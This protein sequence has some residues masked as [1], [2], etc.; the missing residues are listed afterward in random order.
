MK[1]LFLSVPCIFF[2]SLSCLY[3]QINRI[4]YENGFT[5]VHS[6]K[7]GCGIVSVVLFLKGGSFNETDEQAG[8]TNLTA[9]LLLKGTTDRDAAK[10]AFETE[11]LGASMG[12]GSS[13]DYTE[14]SMIVPA[15]N[16]APAFPIFCD[17]VNNPA[18]PEKELEKEREKVMAA[19]RSKS[20]RIFDTAY[21]C[22]NE[23]IYAGHPYHK[24]S[25][26]YEATVSS[27]TLSQIAENY[28]K[29]FRPEN[30]VMSVFGDISEENIKAIV[31]RNF[32]NIKIF[33]TSLNTNKVIVSTDIKKSAAAAGAS[34]V[35][36][37]FQGKF[38]QSY[39]FCGFLVPDVDQQEYPALKLIND[40]TGGGMGSRIFENLREKSGLVYEAD[41][42][43]PSRCSTS[44]FAVYAGTS[45]E[46]VEKVEQTINEEMKKLPS[47]TQ[48]E[49]ND[50]REYLK[51]TYLIDHR[52]I[53]RQAWYLGWWETMGK[54]F[55]YD[56][57]YVEAIDAVT[58]PDI[59]NV[60]EKYLIPQKMTGV[61]IK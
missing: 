6:E 33:G 22:F 57:G 2:V 7:K 31:F 53:E 9:R 38:Q 21:D 13:N 52:K 43:Y 35:K 50:A 34:P 58:V 42:F 11:S 5:L 48:Q 39:Y 10:I 60:C 51:G 4:K 37:I 59:K 12:A 44:A 61:I 3:P 49:L 55:E 54:G 30:M 15:E 24:P 1:K 19:I 23:T 16:F 25:V 41:S 56:S 18:F 29:N 32:G 28:R 17:I 26:G 8:I 40:I 20:D 46:N 47:V 27:L 36:K 14:I 45:K